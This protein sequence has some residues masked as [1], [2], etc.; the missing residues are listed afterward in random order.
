MKKIFLVC[1]ALLVLAGTAA[2][3]QTETRGAKMTVRVS[4]IDTSKADDTTLVGYVFMR[5]YSREYY[6]SSDD[7]EK[8]IKKTFEMSEYLPTM[9]EVR[10]AERLLLEQYPIIMPGKKD[11][12]GKATRPRLKSYVRQYIFGVASDGKRY[13]WINAVSKEET[14]LKD[15]LEK[16]LVHVRDGGHYFWQALL[17]LDDGTMVFNMVNGEA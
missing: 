7:F 4:D 16:R 8:S 2:M 12:W 11:K 17:N 3:A 6:E 13:V 5:H 15:V 10:A 14:W 9:E 1:T